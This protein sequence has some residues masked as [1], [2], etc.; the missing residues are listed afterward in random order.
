MLRPGD[1]EIL[2]DVRARVGFGRIRSLHIGG[3]PVPVA[4]AEFFLALGL[5]FGWCSIASRAVSAAVCG[6]GL[7]AAIL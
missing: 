6:S 1:E 3:A 4:L 5:P 7:E 2:A